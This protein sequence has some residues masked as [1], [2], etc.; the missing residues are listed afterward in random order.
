M[1]GA[2]STEAFWAGDI[3][4]ALDVALAAGWKCL[5]L[6]LRRSELRAAARELLSC[7]NKTESTPLDLE[8]AFCDW[9]RQRSAD[10][11]AVSVVLDRDTLPANCQIDRLHQHGVRRVIVD[12]QKFA[13]SRLTESPAALDLL[14]S[15]ADA[16]ADSGLHLCLETQ[17]PGCANYR[18][19]LQTIAGL[20]HA[21]CKL[22]FDTGRY[23]ALNIES[24]IETALLRV[25]GHLGSVRLTDLDMGDYNAG[26]DWPAGKP[27]RFVPL[28]Q[29]GSLELARLRQILASVAFSGGWSWSFTAKSLE[30]FRRG[31]ESSTAA[32]RNA[33]WMKD[34]G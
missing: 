3:P 5:E 10:V 26:A 32:L 30:D 28:G 6:D 4:A 24:V 20:N 18:D 16:A 11:N 33:G 13:A 29:G 21:A 27:V 15:W 2:V 17:S 1:N 31:F 12:L 19:M 7:E 23:Q 9:L 34:E 25:I 22:N 8:L 14:R